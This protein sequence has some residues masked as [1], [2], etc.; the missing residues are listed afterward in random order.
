M[1]TNQGVVGSI[2]A[3][4]TT[5]HSSEVKGLVSREAGPFSFSACDSGV[6]AFPARRSSGAEAFALALAQAGIVCRAE[7]QLI[8]LHKVYLKPVAAQKAQSWIEYS[9]I[10]ESSDF[11]VGHRSRI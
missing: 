4:R 9:L 6:G 5:L 2:P 7:G 8:D 1:A 11:R 10:L 3:G